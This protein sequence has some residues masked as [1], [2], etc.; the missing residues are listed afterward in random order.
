LSITP[1]QAKAARQLLRLSQDDIAGRLGVSKSVISLFERGTT[2]PILNLDRL[3]AVFEAAG[4][5][6]VAGEPGAQQK[7]SSGTIRATWNQPPQRGDAK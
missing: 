5:A 1:G 3:R 2:P 6:F 7:P 4:I